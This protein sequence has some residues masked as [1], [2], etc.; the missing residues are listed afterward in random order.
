[1]HKPYL[2]NTFKASF[3]ET[4]RL[5]TQTKVIKLVSIYKVMFYA[6]RQRLHKQHSHAHFTKDRIHG[7]AVVSFW[8]RHI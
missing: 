3:S 4:S 6:V 7:A 5:Q 1:M 8:P 2:A